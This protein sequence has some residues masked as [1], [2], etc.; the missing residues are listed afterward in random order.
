VPLTEIE[1][2][3]TKGILATILATAGLTKGILVSLPSVL[4][5]AD[6]VN[7]FKT[8]LKTYVLSGAYS[9]VS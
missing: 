7:S 1:A 9:A 6:S 4:R 8:G 3:L 2:G 5:V